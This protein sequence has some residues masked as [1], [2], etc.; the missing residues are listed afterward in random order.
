MCAVVREEKKQLPCFVPRPSPLGNDNNNSNNT[1]KSRLHFSSE[2]WWW[3]VGGTS[4]TEPLLEALKG[5][6]VGGLLSLLSP[7]V[8]A[9]PAALLLL[10]IVVV[11]VLVAVP[12]GV[13]VPPHDLRLRRWPANCGHAPPQQHVSPANAKRCAL[14]TACVRWRVGVK[15][16]GAY[17]WCC[18]RRAEV[19]AWV[20]P[21]A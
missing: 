20:P 11:S 6:V 15:G 4:T 19:A 17:I 8:V 3:R 5:D 21:F 18:R 14:G 16:K 7:V 1:W 9:S 2:A 12:V 13:S 10:A